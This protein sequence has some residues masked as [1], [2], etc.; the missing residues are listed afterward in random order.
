[1]LDVATLTMSERELGV[2]TC[3]DDQPY[4]QPQIVKVVA[5]FFQMSVGV[6]F[7]VLLFAGLAVVRVWKACEWG[8]RS[9]RSSLTPVGRIAIARICSWRRAVYVFYLG[10]PA[11]WTS[12]QTSL[13]TVGERIFRPPQVEAS[14]SDFGTMTLESRRDSPVKVLPERLHV[15]SEPLTAAIL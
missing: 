8:P 14:S 12:S 1:M 13:I 11:S 7:L 4:D 15:P 6:G 5:I 10:T 9:L 3:V 2:R